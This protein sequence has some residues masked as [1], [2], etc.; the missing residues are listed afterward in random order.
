MRGFNCYDTNLCSWCDTW[1]RFD[2]AIIVV[3]AGESGVLDVVSFAV[4]V[5]VLHLTSVVDAAVAMLSLLSL[6]SSLSSLLQQQL[7]LLPLLLMKKD[8]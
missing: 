7:L 6:L 8:I 2:V 5:I 1:C 3:V 4:V